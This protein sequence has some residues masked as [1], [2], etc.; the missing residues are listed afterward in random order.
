MRLEFVNDIA[1]LDDMELFSQNIQDLNCESCGSLGQKS[2]P[3]EFWV[4][5]LKHTAVML[6]NEGKVAC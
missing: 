4:G 2:Y 1:K 5:S 6:R 3:E